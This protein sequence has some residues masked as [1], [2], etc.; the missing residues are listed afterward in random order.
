MMTEKSLC[1][2]EMVCVFVLQLFYA[3]RHSDI[4]RREMANE[5]S[6]LEPDL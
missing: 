2:R 5:I 4:C 3:R 1:E 6:L